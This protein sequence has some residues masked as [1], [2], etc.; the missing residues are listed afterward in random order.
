MSYLQTKP[1][2]LEE[3]IKRNDEDYQAMFKKELKKTESYVN[4]LN[5]IE[6]SLVIQELHYHVV[7]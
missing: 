6:Y 2:S 3:A 1:G 5:K 7:F 4:M